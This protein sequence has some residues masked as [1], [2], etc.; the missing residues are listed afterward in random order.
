[1]KKIFKAL[2]ITIMLFSVVEG[3]VA[4]TSNITG[5]CTKGN[6][7]NGT[8]TFFSDDGDI[9]TGTFVKGDFS[10]KHNSVVL[11]TGHTL[12]GQFDNWLISNGTLKYPTGEI[13]SGEFN[14]LLPNGVGKMVHVDG[15]VY[16]GEWLNGKKS[17]I[18]KLDYGDGTWYN[19]GWV[20]NEWDGKGT[21]F[22]G[23]TVSQTNYQHGKNS[24]D[25]N[26]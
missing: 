8:G 20:D 25:I 14:N 17:G 4:K 10:G 2:F 3:S 24:V 5:Q 12:S 23:T 16:E 19:G 15:S 18:G 21:Y 26:K 1:M 6:C 7:Y 9:F 22:D 13:Y 11:S